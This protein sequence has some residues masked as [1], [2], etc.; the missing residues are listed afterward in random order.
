MLTASGGLVVAL[1]KQVQIRNDNML[2]NGCQWI[3]NGYTLILN[4]EVANNFY[5][6]F[7]ALPESRQIVLTFVSDHSSPSS[8][9]FCSYH[10]FLFISCEFAASK[11]LLAEKNPLYRLGTG[12]KKVNSCHIYLGEAVLF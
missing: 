2:N 11:P 5:T 4:E 3:R 10:L 8:L 9:L 7:I 6:K 12:L 1:R